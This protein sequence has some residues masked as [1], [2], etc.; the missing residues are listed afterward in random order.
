MYGRGLKDVRII[1]GAGRENVSADALSRSPHAP[2]PLEGVGEGEMQVGQV[3]SQDT[4]SDRSNLSLLQSVHGDLPSTPPACYL[5]EQKK[6]PKLFEIINFLRTSSLPADEGWARKV[7]LQSP[8]FTI[9]DDTLY[10]VD[11]RRRNRQVVVPLPHHRKLLEET[12]AGRYG[13][14]FSG[15]KLYESLSLHWWWEGMYRDAMEFSKNCPE[16]AIAKGTG[17]MHRPPLCPIPVARPFQIWGVDILDLLK[18]EQGNQHA[19]VFQDLFTKWP[20]VYPAPDQKAVRLACLLAE[21]IVCLFGVPEVMLSDRGTNLLSHLMSD[22]CQLLGAKKLNTTSYHPQCDGTVERFN[23]TLKSMLRKHA[24]RFGMQWDK[25]LPCVLWSYRNTPHSST[26]EKPSF[27][28]F[29]VDCRSSTETA[30]LTVPKRIPVDIPDYRQELMLSLSSA[31]EL[32]QQ[33]IRK[34]QQRYKAQ[35]DKKSSVPDLKIG[36]WVLVR[37]PQEETGRNR[38]LSRPWHG[39]YRITDRRD[40]DVSVTKVYFPSEGAI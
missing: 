1:Y 25:F 33:S 3:Q 36:E 24:A 40:P 30:F 22:V 10:Y 13:G 38:K 19:I 7:A 15:R 4:D 8:L 16:C 23:R 27:L 29:G 35:Y 37:F 34:A 28:M 11:S 18:T 5:D 14:H 39:P 6:D 21:E 17:R 12:H 2:A 9:V 32:A 31:R 20:M 26:G